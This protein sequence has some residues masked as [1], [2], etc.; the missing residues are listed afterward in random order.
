MRAR[1]VAIGAVI[2]LT[3]AACGN[4]ESDN[5]PTTQPTNPGGSSVTTVGAADLQKN[6]P[7]DAPG[8]SD[9]EIGVAVITATTN[10]LGGYYG[11][12]A[13]GIQAYFDYVN[14]Q[15]GIYGRQLKIAKH[16][17]DQMTNNQQAVKASLSQD[18]AFAT[19]I[20]G[21]LFTGAPDI[22]ASNPQMPTFI[23][24]I[25]PEMAGN[26]NIFGTVGALCFNCIGQ[27]LPYLAQ[28]EGKKTV[29]VLAYGATASSKECGTASRDSFKKYGFTV[30]FFD[31]NIGFAQPDLSS[32]VSEMKKAGVELVAI[33]MDA[34]EAIILASEMKRQGLNAVLTLPNS[35][36]EQYVAENANVLEGSYISPGFVPFEKDVDL[37]DHELIKEWVGK[38]GK[39]IRELTVEGW[40]AAMM[41]VHG[42]KLAGPEFS[43]EKL[44]SSLNQETHFTANG[45]KVPIDWTKQHE[46]P[47]K[48]PEAR[49]D[50][51]CNSWVKVQGG[52]MVPILDEPGKPWVC[53]VG[54]QEPDQL[55]QTPTYE[56]FAPTTG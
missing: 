42:L 22:A 37:P 9:D 39:T 6:V 54:G 28:A 24:N 12:Y 44:I 4:S 47:R 3:V 48:N 56:N 38:S 15:G 30:G 51:V 26:P 53:M 20:A 36:D 13:D 8:V 50:Y 35:Y 10:F 34:K 1:I 21:P 25:N 33:C 17:D 40:A 7:V 32:Q 55:T 16:R 27:A 29:A 45:L 11:E 23:W 43:Q 19:F 5:K 14:S 41:F 2:A 49:S 52:K 31:N 46:D 18:N